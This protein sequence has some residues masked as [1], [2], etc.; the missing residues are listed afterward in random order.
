MEETKS[1]GALR[2]IGETV[3][4]TGVVAYVLRFW[5]SRFPQIK[6]QKRR[7]RRYYSC[8][9]IAIIEMIKSLLYEHGYTING[10]QKFLKNNK[11]Y[12][13]NISLNPDIK[14]IEPPFSEGNTVIQQKISESSAD[15]IVTLEEIYRGLCALRSRLVTA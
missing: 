12:R 7:G 14:N 4:E 3:T 6:P 15:A 11:N 1:P 2:T 8:E 10:V 5:E 13:N 9:D